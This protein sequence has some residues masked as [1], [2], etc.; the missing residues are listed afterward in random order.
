MLIAGVNH[1]MDKS[2]AVSWDEV[3]DASDAKF[4]NFKAM[5]TNADGSTEAKTLA[6]LNITSINLTADVKTTGSGF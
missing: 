2:G 5:V 3:L 4:A 6:Q 1:F